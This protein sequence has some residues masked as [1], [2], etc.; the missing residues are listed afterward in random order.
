VSPAVFLV[1]P[2]LI[3]T[4]TWSQ[5]RFGSVVGGLLAAL[6]LTSGPAILLVGLA[7][8]PTLAG[9]VAANSF[10]GLLVAAGFDL[11]YAVVARKR[12]WVVALLVGGG[13]YVVL[14]VVLRWAA[15]PPVAGAAVTLGGIG[16][17]VR[18]WPREAGPVR[19]VVAPPRWDLPARMV[20]AGSVTATITEVAPTLGG[21]LTG[22]LSQ[23]PILGC[24][25]AVFTHRQ[26]GPAGAVLL[27]RAIVR[28]LPCCVVF[29]ATL[30]L[31]LRTFGLGPAFGL[32]SVLALA[33]QVG[34]YLGQ[35]RGGARPV[36]PAANHQNG[37]D[38]VDGRAEVQVRTDLQRDA[39]R[40]DQQ[41]DDPEL[42]EAKALRGERD[43]GADEDP[44]VRPWRPGRVQVGQQ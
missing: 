44:R 4:V 24:T 23:L 27:L 28:G 19:R 25:M 10:P 21:P 18:C 33:V 39:D 32:A 13:V 3:G 12:S 16:L 36:E 37:E 34:V 8:G 5:R 9:A 11:G 31:T 30:A 20:I 41:P 26:A 14:A 43:D 38:D 42:D 22:L 6:P 1:S 2:L 17:M 29:Y 35:G 7:H 40:V 15:L